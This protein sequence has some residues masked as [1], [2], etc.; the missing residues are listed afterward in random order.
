MAADTPEVGLGRAAAFAVPLIVLLVAVL[1]AISELV[2]MFLGLPSSL[3]LPLAVRAVGWVLVVTGL[4]TGGWVFRYWSPA[5]MMTSTYVTFMKMFRR[6]PLTDA[7]GRN[8]PLVVEGPQ[9]YT[10]N[11]LYFGLV[12]MMFG[13]AVAGASTVV[14]VWAVALL[15][16][17]WLIL[18][19]FEERELRMLFGE[20]YE[21]YME[22]VPMLVPFTRR[23]RH[24]RT[25]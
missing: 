18:I 19:P 5:A 23:R 22:Q 2:V 11:P 4:M 13:W 3:G 8:E 16:W 1:L 7:M 12:V 9:K 20:K 24:D 25:G 17:F 14:L 10:R 15:L 6:A 21:R